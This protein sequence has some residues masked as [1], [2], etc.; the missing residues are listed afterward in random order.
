MKNK[1]SSITDKIL[2]IIMIVSLGITSS[3]FAIY[4]DNAKTFKKIIEEQEVDLKQKSTEIAKLEK[5]IEL[6]DKKNESLEKVIEIKDKQIE[7]REELIKTLK[8]LNQKQKKI[9][10]DSNF[11]A[12]SKGS[13]STTTATINMNASAYIAL[14]SEGCSGKTASG[15]DVKNTIYYNGMRIIASD[16]DVLPMYSIVEI[17]GFS[18]RFIVLDTGGAIKGNKIDI[19]FDSHTNA[20]K[21]GRK[22]L[23][24]KVL[25]YGRG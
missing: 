16:L 10:E 15:Y 2:A 23:K 9:I 4:Y 18:D 19:L 1:V 13:D 11:N 25:R 8:E 7:G 6:K 12:K 14:C 17:E 21:F 20:I 24:V 5:T 22:N 3:G